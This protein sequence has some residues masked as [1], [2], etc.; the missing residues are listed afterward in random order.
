MSLEVGFEVSEAQGRLRAV[1]LPDTSCCAIVSLHGNRTLTMKA[2]MCWL[3]VKISLTS[4][5]F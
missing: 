1:Y 5:Q 3:Y 4:E 2:I